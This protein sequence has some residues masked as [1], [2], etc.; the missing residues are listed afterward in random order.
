V[1]VEP[2]QLAERQIELDKQRTLSYP[3]LLARK[4]ARMSASPLAFLRG[5]AP[6]FY[7]ILAQQSELAQGPDGQGFIQ[8]D[9]HL[10][11]FGAYSPVIHE[12]GTWKKGPATFNLNDFDD[13]TRGAW[14]WD[15]LRL[16]TSLLLAG[17][18]LGQSGATVL[19]LCELLIE[20]HVAAAFSAAALPAVPGAIAKLVQRVQERSRKRLLDDRTASDGSRRHFV[21]GERYRDVSDEI[22]RELPHALALFAERCA[23]EGGPRSEQLQILDFAFRIAGTGSLGALRVAVLTRGKG[24]VD[25]EWLFDLKEQLPSSV[26]ALAGAA[27]ASSGSRAAEVE[28]AFRSCVTPPPR[29][30]GTSRIGDKEVLVRRLTPQEDKLSL[31][32]LKADEL[33][34]LAAYLGALLGQAH[35]RGASAAF[36][37][38]T[39][40][41][42]AGLL[43]R[44][45]RLAG[46]HEAT[47]LQWCL[48]TR[49]V[50]LQREGPP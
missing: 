31:T 34:P 13:A 5:A 37:P 33:R 29:M 25:G 14:R 46:L 1:V 28:Q 23:A 36:T 27:N 50:P 19:S 11:N 9:A 10:E 16:A 38:W 41:E 26:N 12:A 2:K 6:L 30:L 7:E 21:R 4:R 20:R 3:A 48:L 49:E 39:E 32:Q 15:V 44:A 18:E 47:Y 40:L 45:V 42:R 22:A 17:R 24:G 43:E 8:G 35:R